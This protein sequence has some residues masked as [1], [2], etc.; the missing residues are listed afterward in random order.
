MCIRTLDGEIVIY[1][2]RNVNS[3]LPICNLFATFLNNSLEIR[4]FASQI[5]AKAKFF[6]LTFALIR[7]CHL[8]DHFPL[9]MV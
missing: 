7:K 9:F 5:F 4:A 8:F 6:V 2:S 1:L 3:Y